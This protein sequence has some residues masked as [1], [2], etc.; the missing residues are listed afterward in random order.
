MWIRVPRIHFETN[1]LAFQASFSNIPGTFTEED[2]L[3]RFGP[4][5]AHNY[6]FYK[7]PLPFGMRAP[8]CTAIINFLVEEDLA[9]WLRRLHGSVILDAR[10][11]EFVIE[12]D[13]M[14]NQHL[15]KFPVV[16]ADEVEGSIEETDEFLEFQAHWEG[17]DEAS[18][19]PP[20]AADVLQ[21]IMLLEIEEK[22]AKTSKHT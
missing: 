21:K 10:G 1:L 12:G 14:V 2:F 18:N 6:F 15:P 5:P 3:E 11:Q 22:K 7:P 9:V 20:I 13:V 19:A 17:T 4:L 8:T 16:E